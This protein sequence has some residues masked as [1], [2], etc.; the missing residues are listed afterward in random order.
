MP[1]IKAL[2]VTRYEYSQ[3]PQKISTGENK[4]IKYKKLFV[5]VVSL[6]HQHLF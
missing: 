3:N 2:R 6:K 1:T 5:T 4:A